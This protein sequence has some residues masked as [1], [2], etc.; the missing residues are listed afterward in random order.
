MKV[1]FAKAVAFVAAFCY[2]SSLAFCAA[3]ATELAE[4]QEYGDGIIASPSPEALQFNKLADSN[5]L[6]NNRSAVT[7][8]PVPI[9]DDDD[10]CSRTQEMKSMVQHCATTLSR[11]VSAPI[12]TDKVSSKETDAYT[13]RGCGSSGGST[14]QKNKMM[15]TDEPSPCGVKSFRGTDDRVGSTTETDGDC[16]SDIKTVKVVRGMIK[17]IQQL[18]HLYG[19]FTTE[20]YRYAI[21]FY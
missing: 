4:G 9:Y 13:H 2:L 14:M 3:V 21:L 7:Q 17:N 19:A 8:Q 16:D 11:G 18:V 12:V 6:N 20:Y 5:S 15:T 1:R 10:P